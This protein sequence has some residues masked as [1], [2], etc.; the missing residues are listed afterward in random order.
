MPLIARKIASI[1]DGE[2]DLTIIRGK[3][4]AATSPPTLPPDARQQP[5]HG[6][7]LGDPTR[8]LPRITLATANRETS[9]A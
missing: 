2:G 3:S 8:R 7:P 5:G 6:W 9:W 1:G 4:S